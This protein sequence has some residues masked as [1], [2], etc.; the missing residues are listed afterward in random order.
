MAWLG[1]VAIGLAIFLMSRDTVFPGAS[2]LLPVAGAA[3]FIWGNTGQSTSAGRILSLRPIVFVGLISYSLYLWHW[4][5]FAYL[6]YASDATEPSVIQRLVALVVSGLLAIVAWR[7]V[8]EPVR[9]RVVLN[10]TPRLLVTVGLSMLVLLATAGSMVQSLGF[11]GRLPQSWTLFSNPS[12]NVVL[13][14]HSGNLLN[15]G[16]NPPAEKF[17]FVVWGDSHANVAAP[18]FDTVAKR[19]GLQG[20]NAA[21][22]GRPPIPGTSIFWDKMLSE[23]NSEVLNFIKTH[24]I[25]HVFLVARWSQFIEGPTKYDQLNGRG[26]TDPLLR[27]SPTEKPTRES[28]EVCL[29][30]GLERLIKDLEEAGCTIWIVQQVPDQNYDILRKS[31]LEYRGL[32]WTSNA[33]PLT[34][35]AFNQHQTRVNAIFTGLVSHNVRLIDLSNAMFDRDGIAITSSNG[36]PLYRDNSH[37]SVNGSELYIQPIVEEALS[38]ISKSNA[39]S[40]ATP[41]GINENGSDQK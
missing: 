34:R 19:L 14:A 16:I 5:V 26:F 6:R 33:I 10:S 35:E 38:R 11:P 13:K 8:E 30:T 41:D 9:R 15:L 1:L 2:A 12:Q 4:P 20:I 39:A 18:V 31:F 28:S 36:V 23:W 40:S 3:S 27:C 24:R 37:L 21:K 29:R 17:S 25:P 7:T 32:P 22:G